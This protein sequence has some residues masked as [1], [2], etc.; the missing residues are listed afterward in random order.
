[1]KLK[2]Q[3]Y[4]DAQVIQYEGINPYRN[5]LKYY[6]I[7]WPGKKKKKKNSKSTT[8]LGNKFIIS[9]RG[10]RRWNKKSQDTRQQLGV[11]HTKNVSR[12]KMNELI[13][14]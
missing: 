9:T 6:G 12:M 7:I 8:R 5:R 14:T 10:E 11:Q 3:R 13:T 4:R 2:L 1:M